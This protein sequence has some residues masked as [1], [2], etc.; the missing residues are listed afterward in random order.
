MLT[1]LAFCRFLHFAA[2]M[3]LFGASVFVW[4]FA[5][6]ALAERLAPPVKRM[7][8]VAIVVAAITALAW[9]GLE[10]GQM[11]EGWSDSVS[12]EALSGVLFDTEFGSVWLWRMALALVL[13]CALA[14]RRHDRFAFIAIVSGL[15]LGSLGLVGHA[16]MQSGAI[17]ALHRFNHS[18]HLLLAGGWIGGLAPFI[19]CLGH[20]REARSEVGVALRRFSGVGHFVVA[21]ILFTGVVNTILTLGA[22]PIDFSS[23]YQ[24][25]LAAKIAIVAAMIALALFNRYVLAPRLKQDS[26]SALRALRIDSVIELALGA[27]VLA[28]V[29][30]FGILAPV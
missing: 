16:T 19:L 18:V 17:G 27:I 28:L 14:L 25:L 10:A 23:L 7:I 2:V 22:W 30:A 8:G 1:A 4:A 26:E 9:V 29:S 5:P 13:L 3:L 12:L 6:A 24:A 21:L 20:S 11:G 15:L